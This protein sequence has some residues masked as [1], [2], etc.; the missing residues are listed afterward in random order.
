MIKLY[1]MNFVYIFKKNLAAILDAI[2]DF[3]SRPHFKKNLCQFSDDLLIK[4]NS[5]EYNKVSTPSMCHPTS[6]FH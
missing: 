2:L 1:I 4:A 3:S 5:L 6:V